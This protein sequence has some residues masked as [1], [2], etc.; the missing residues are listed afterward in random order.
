MSDDAAV[1]FDEDDTRSA[2]G[3]PRRRRL[4]RRAAISGL[5][6]IAIGTAG[7]G[8]AYWLGYLPSGGA[9][10]QPPVFF[11]L[12][13]MTVNLNSVD[14]R[15]QYLKIRASLEMRDERVKAAIEQVLP[16]VLDAF[17]VYLRELRPSDLE[18]SAG[19]HRLK[20]ELVRRVNLA[21][22]PAEID[23]VVFEELIVQ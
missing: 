19:L 4:S 6:L 21:I 9:G 11:D 22:H 16:R 23:G 13:E 8:G 17:Q 18:G 7:V 2:D 10:D 5:G 1:Q 3:A 20:E 12:P 15:P 14:D